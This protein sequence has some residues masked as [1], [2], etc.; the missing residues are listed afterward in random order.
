VFNLETGKGTWALDGIPGNATG[1]LTV[2]P[3]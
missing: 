1:S 3:Q 2:Q